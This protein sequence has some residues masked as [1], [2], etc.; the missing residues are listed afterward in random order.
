[1]WH[2]SYINIHILTFKTSSHLVRGNSNK[3]PHGC[4]NSSTSHQYRK[5]IQPQALPVHITISKPTCTPTLTYMYPHS[6]QHLY[7][8]V[9][10]CPNRKND[11]VYH[12]HPSAAEQSTNATDPSVFVSRSVLWC[13][14]SIFEF[15]FGQSETESYRCCVGWG[16]M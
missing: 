13:I 10:L 2:F 5:P 3:N 11:A 1:M 12:H 4:R 6:T 8:S 7:D 9:S 15:L 16:Y 14:R